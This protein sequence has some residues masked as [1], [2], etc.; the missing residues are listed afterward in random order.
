MRVGEELGLGVWCVRWKINR[1]QTNSNQ[2]VLCCS[3][4]LLTTQFN[5]L[6]F[7]F[8]EIKQIVLLQIITKAA[9]IMLLCIPP[10]LQ[11]TGIKSYG[12]F[13]FYKRWKGNDVTVVK[14]SCISVFPQVVSRKCLA[15]YDICATSEDLAPAS[16]RVLLQSTCLFAELVHISPGRGKSSS[17]S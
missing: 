16:R 17:D 4:C 2:E 13:S 3:P 11:L 8:W 14:I 10:R 12:F 15:L 6:V 9:V 7:G 1:I 5:K